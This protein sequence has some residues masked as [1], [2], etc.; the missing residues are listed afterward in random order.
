MATTVLFV[1]LGFFIMRVV[2]KW[3]TFRYKWLNIILTVI[4]T[5]VGLF[6]MIFFTCSIVYNFPQ[7]YNNL[8]R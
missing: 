5:V 4:C 1:L 7:V 6:L 8:F 2:P 3:I